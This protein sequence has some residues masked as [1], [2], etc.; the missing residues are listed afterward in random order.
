MSLRLALLVVA[1][2][3]MPSMSAAQSRWEQC[4]ATKTC[5]AEVDKLLAAKEAEIRASLPCSVFVYANDWEPLMNLTGRACVV[6]EAP[7]VVDGN[8]ESVWAERP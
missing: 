7:T 8:F 1:I 5:K 4:L 6:I 2:L 3:V